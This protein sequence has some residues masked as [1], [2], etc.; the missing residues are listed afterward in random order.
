MPRKN[1]Q[2]PAKRPNFRASKDFLRIHRNL[3]KPLVPLQATCCLQS[4]AKY[5][6]KVSYFSP[7]PNI[8]VACANE[9]VSTQR[10]N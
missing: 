4:W 3:H 6:A 8:N 2:K 1:A 7:S 9:Y 5:M 10:F